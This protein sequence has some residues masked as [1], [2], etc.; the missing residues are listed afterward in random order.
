VL[1]P[2]ISIQRLE[3][4]WEDPD[5][6]RPERW[7]ETLPPSEKLISGWSNTLAFGDGP[8]GCIGLRLGEQYN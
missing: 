5:E 8:R 6:F 7:L 1:I 4:V 2:A 3:S